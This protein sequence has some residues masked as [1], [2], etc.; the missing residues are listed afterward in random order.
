MTAYVVQV[1]GWMA[2]VYARNKKD[3]VREAKALAPGASLLA[4]DVNESHVR[5]ATDE[6]VAWY[7]AM[8]G[9]TPPLAPIKRVTWQQEAAHQYRATRQGGAERLPASDHTY[10]LLLHVFVEYEDGKTREWEPTGS[11]RPSW[12]LDALE[13]AKGGAPDAPVAT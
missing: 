7:E 9:V 5:R 13:W 3:A 10:D 6:D 4:S 1:F 8:T 2:I 12:V 11:S